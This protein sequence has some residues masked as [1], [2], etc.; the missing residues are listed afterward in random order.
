M[1]RIDEPDGGLAAVPERIFTKKLRPA[2]P[3]RKVKKVYVDWQRFDRILNTALTVSIWLG[4]AM[5]IV[6]AAVLYNWW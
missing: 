2:A 6:Q 4:I 5:V 1:I 3:A